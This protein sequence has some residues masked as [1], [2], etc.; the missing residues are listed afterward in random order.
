[1][2]EFGI[3]SRI[4]ASVP[5]ENGIMENN[6]NKFRHA[7]TIKFIIPKLMNV[8]VQE[9]WCGYRQ[10]N[11]VPTRPVLKIK[12]GMATDVSILY[13]LRI[14]I[15]TGLNASVQILRISANLGNTLM[16]NNVYTSQI[17]V[18]KEPTGTDLSVSQ[19]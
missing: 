18:L 8:P 4:L 7:N 14:P 10:K 16:E 17:N 11:L 6:V 15:S 13:V 2:G 5:Q 12:C 19:M 9:G 1:M 3:Q